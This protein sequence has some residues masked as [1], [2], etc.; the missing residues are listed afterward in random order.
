[1]A[2]LK[3]GQVEIDGEIKVKE[4]GT[5]YNTGELSLLEWHNKIMEAQHK[6]YELTHAPHVMLTLSQEYEGIVSKNPNYTSGCSAVGFRAYLKDGDTLP[7]NE[8]LHADKGE[9]YIN[10]ERRTTDYTYNGNDT[11]LVSVW[12]FDVVGGFTVNLSTQPTFTPHE[13]D[14][15]AFG[16]PPTINS[17]YYLYAQY[18][19]THNYT[20]PVAPKACRV[21]EINGVSNFID[22]TQ[23][24]SSIAQEV[25]SNCT[26]F[27]SNVLK[28]AYNLKKLSLPECKELNVNGRTGGLIDGSQLTQYEWGKLKTLIGGSSAGTNAL[29]LNAHTVVIPNTVET[30]SG[31]ICRLN[32]T[33]KLECNKAKSIS[34]N[35]CFATPT[36]FIMCENW[37]ATINISVAAGD[38]TA[39]RF[40][41]L[42][43]NLL[44]DH[45][46]DV[47]QATLKYITIPASIYDQL[48]DD[49]TIDIALNKGWMID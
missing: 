2:L 31:I 48:Y 6:K 8:F 36:N 45:I 16:T 39:D 41:D 22:T 3:E 19:K 5:L 32:N 11:E 29:F 18:I 12:V 7:I 47:T 30:M 44:V 37:D 21:M 13:I 46:E 1:M 25:K 33:I 15:R 9:W 49:G 34:T 43:T 4:E 14:I 26:K 42:F 17:D 24:I 28:S 20:L 40:V 35:W 23:K 27:T 38:W 10:G